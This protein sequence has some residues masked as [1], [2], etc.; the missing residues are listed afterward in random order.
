MPYNEQNISL[1]ELEQLRGQMCSFLI[2]SKYLKVFIRRQT[3]LIKGVYAN[4][5]GENHFFFRNELIPI[6][7]RLKEELREWKHATTLEVTRCWLPA[8]EQNKKVMTL[9]TDASLAQLRLQVV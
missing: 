4:H 9:H 3:E 2:A 7:E 6:T 5:V 8:R 1:H